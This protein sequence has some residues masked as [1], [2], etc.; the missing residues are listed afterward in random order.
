MSHPF[1]CRCG[2][3]GIFGNKVLPVGG[4]GC[5][6]GEAGTGLARGIT[7]AGGTAAS[8]RKT[9]LRSRSCR[10]RADFE[11]TGEESFSRSSTRTMPLWL[12]HPRT[13]AAVSGSRRCGP[14][15][16]AYRDDLPRAL[17]LHY[18]GGSIAAIHGPKQVHFRDKL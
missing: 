1:R 10:S 13:A 15:D 4:F 16:R 3:N 17:L 14:G 11:E 8:R 2:G 18:R 7:G 5:R 6:D 9:A 12:A